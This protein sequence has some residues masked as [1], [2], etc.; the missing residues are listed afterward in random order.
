MWAMPQYVSR[1]SHYHERKE[2]I[3]YVVSGKMK[4]LFL[5]MDNSEKEEH[6]LE[7]GDRI[8]IQPRCAHLFV[9]LEETLVVEYSP[10]IFDPEDNT[11]VDFQ[12]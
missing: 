11:R 1:G 2:E 4:A 10:Q 12:P 9:G 5:D 3:F 8:R 7:K 6:V